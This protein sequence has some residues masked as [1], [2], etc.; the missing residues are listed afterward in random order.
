MLHR[1][2]SVLVRPGLDRLAGAVEVDETY[3][4]WTPAEHGAPASKPPVEGC[5]QLRLNG[6]PRNG[7]SIA[8]S[9]AKETLHDILENERDL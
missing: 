7:L 8:S 4:A 9:C 5:S 2:R 6:Y 3:I 1:L